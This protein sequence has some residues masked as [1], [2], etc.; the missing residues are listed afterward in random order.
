MNGP[1]QFN[2]GDL[3]RADFRTSQ[4][5]DATNTALQKDLRFDYRYQP[6]RVAIGLSL[7]LSASPSL[8]S[9][10]LGKPIR[11]ETLFGQ[12]EGEMA[13]WV[14]LICS[15]A[16]LQVPTKKQLFDLVAGHWARG[17]QLLVKRLDLYEGEPHEF[18]LSIQPNQKN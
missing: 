7:S 18:L 16:G 4:L 10:V 9:D 15:H 1:V 8:P 17:L 14:S 5:A 13:L 12:E 2:L 11:G 3:F 6:A